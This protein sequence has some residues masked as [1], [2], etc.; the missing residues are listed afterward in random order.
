MRDADTTVEQLR[1]VLR[2]FV[3]ERAWQPFH[4]PKNLAMALAIEAAE[5]MEHFQWL[6][7]EESLA[8]AG[9]DARREAVGAELADVLAY[10]LALA[11]A[12]GLDL[13]AAFADKMRQN[14]RKYPVEA[15]RGRWGAGDDRPARPES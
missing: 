6:T 11:E 7:P 1:A 15:Y 5:L 8:V 9:S 13:A 12:L 4:T 10:T 14:A 2:A 3:A